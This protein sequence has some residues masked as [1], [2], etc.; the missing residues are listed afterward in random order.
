M[1]KLAINKKGISLIEAT[2]AIAILLIG[3]VAAAEIFPLAVKVDK[4]AEQKT[5]AVDLAQSKIEEVFSQGFEN[6]T[7]GTIEPRHR[8]ASSSTNPFYFYERE[9]TVD[10]VIMNGIIDHSDN[11]TAIKRISTT[12]YWRSAV[13]KDEASSSVKLLVSQK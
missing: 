6:I 5:V 3:I 12:I 4:T 10:Y 11:P 9:T 13:S 7:V 2:I 8:L 1:L